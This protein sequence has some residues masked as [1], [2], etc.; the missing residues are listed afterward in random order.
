M[1]IRIDWIKEKYEKQMS[2]EIKERDFDI[3]IRLI[4]KE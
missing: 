4:D 3:R 1:E 2:G